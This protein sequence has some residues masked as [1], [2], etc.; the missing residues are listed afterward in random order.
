MNHKEFSSKG[1]SSKSEKKRESSRANVAKARLAKI[2]R[3]NSNADVKTAEQSSTAD[4]ER[5]TDSAKTH[6]STNSV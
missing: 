1:G 6:A 5:P 4:A 3:A 2:G